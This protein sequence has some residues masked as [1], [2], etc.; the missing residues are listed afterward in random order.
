MKIKNNRTRELLSKSNLMWCLFLCELLVRQLDKSDLVLILFLDLRKSRC[1]VVRCFSFLYLCWCLYDSVE[2]G[3][4]K[5]FS[6]DFQREIIFSFSISIVVP[7][8]PI[9]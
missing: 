5:K 7:T 1:H 3:E 8:K 2:N 4:K 6:C 9:T